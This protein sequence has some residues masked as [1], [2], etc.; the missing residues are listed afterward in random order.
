MN[1]GSDRTLKLTRSLLSKKRDSCRVAPFVVVLV[2]RRRSCD[3]T[4]ERKIKNK[5]G[6]NAEKTGGRRGVIYFLE[7]RQACR[8]WQACMLADNLLSPELN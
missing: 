4:Q 5:T 6:A 7:E 8:L 2:E 3:V 1:L